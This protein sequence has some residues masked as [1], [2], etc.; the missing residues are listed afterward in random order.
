MANSTHNYQGTLDLGDAS[1]LLA[2]IGGIAAGPGYVLA[3]SGTTSEGAPC[4]GLS[5]HFDVISHNTAVVP[6][7]VRCQSLRSVG[8]G[9]SPG[10]GCPCDPPAPP[11]LVVPTPRH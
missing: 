9:L 8:S 10:S 5:Q 11:M 3:L 2:V 7:N 4:Q 6:I 1:A